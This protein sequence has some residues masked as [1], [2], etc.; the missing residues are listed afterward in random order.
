MSD[1]AKL[2]EAREGAGQWRVG[3]RV[4]DHWVESEKPKLRLP[5]KPLLVIS[6]RALGKIGE[7]IDVRAFT[8]AEATSF[9][10]ELGFKMSEGDA[11]SQSNSEAA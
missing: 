6:L 11:N 3:G 8:T 1:A 10:K 5:K 2:F 7:E 9:F 4:R